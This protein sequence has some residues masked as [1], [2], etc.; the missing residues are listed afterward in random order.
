MSCCICA[1]NRVPEG[2]LARILKWEGKPLIVTSFIFFA[3]VLYSSPHPQSPRTTL[4]GALM[5]PRCSSTA[6]PAA[7][8]SR[9]FY[10]FGVREA[11]VTRGK[12][13]FHNRQVDRIDVD[14]WR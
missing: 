5:N 6:H 7:E 14:R 8:L 4:H 10:S 13:G 11:G 12:S 9:L 2:R 3:V 1:V